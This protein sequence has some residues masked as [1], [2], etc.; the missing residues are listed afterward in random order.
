MSSERAQTD[1]PRT[2]RPPEADS[3]VGAAVSTELAPESRDTQIEGSLGPEPERTPVAGSVAPPSG[4]RAEEDTLLSL[5]RPADKLELVI[6]DRL[7]GFEARLDALEARIEGVERRKPAEQGDPA[8]RWW[9][10]VFFLL[11]LAVAWKALEAL[12]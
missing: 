11:A 1:T 6:E 9:I 4:E 3:G 10:W 8:G 12:K 2:P 7:A 5:P